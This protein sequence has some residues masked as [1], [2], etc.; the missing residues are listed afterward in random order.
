MNFQNEMAILEDLKW[1]ITHIQNSFIID[2]SGTCDTAIHS[3]D[4]LT[5]QEIADRK[6]NDLNYDSSPEIRPLIYDICRNRSNTDKLLKEYTTKVLAKRREKE[7]VILEDS[8]HED[9][10]RPISRAELQVRIIILS[11]SNDYV[12]FISPQF[13][14]KQFNKYKLSV[15]TVT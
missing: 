5:V 13:H 1:N 2:P 12:K 14:Q 4:Q 3:R 15:S 10:I 8:D 7:E 6:E 11:L 9:T